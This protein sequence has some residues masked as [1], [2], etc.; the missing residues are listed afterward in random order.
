MS[1]VLVQNELDKLNI[2]LKAAIKAIDELKFP[3]QPKEFEAFLKKLPPLFRLSSICEELYD[4]EEKSTEQEAKSTVAD[5]L[6]HVSIHL[7]EQIKLFLKKV[8]KY[9]PDIFKAE[10]GNKI[11][12]EAPQRP[13][14]E[15]HLNAAFGFYSCSLLSI[16]VNITDRHEE[17]QKSCC[18]DGLIALIFQEIFPLLDKIDWD[19]GSV[20]EELMSRSMDIVYNCCKL[21]ANH[22]YYLEINAVDVLVQLRK[23]TNH[24]E[25]NDTNATALLTL[26]YLIDESNNDKIICGHATIETL[27]R[28][29]TKCLKKLDHVAYGFHAEELADGLQH[30]SVPDENKA[31]ICERG[32]HEVLAALLFN[33]MNDEEIISSC[34]AL[35][36]LCFSEKGRLLTKENQDLMKKLKELSKSETI[37]V[38][39]A[40]VGVLWQLKQAEEKEK[41]AVA[42]SGKKVNGAGHIML[43]YQWDDQKMVK[44]IAATLK[45]RGYIV[46]IDVEKIQGNIMDAMADAVEQASVIVVCI[47]RKYKNSP[48]CRA[49]ADYSFQLKKKV[50]PLMM[51]KDYRPDGWIGLLLGSKLRIDFTCFEA[52]AHNME[53]L[54][55]Q[56]DTICPALPEAQI[57]QNVEEPVQAVNEPYLGHHPLTSYDIPDS[58]AAR[59]PVAEIKN[60]SMNHER[61]GEISQWSN[62]EVLQWLREKSLIGAVKKDRLK[63]L[64]GVHLV[65]LYNLRRE[66]PK[67]YYHPLT[68]AQH[69][70]FNDL[71]DFL[72]FTNHIDKL[73]E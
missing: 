57:T 68:F 70:G 44:D 4:I 8:M 11:E 26:G 43:S 34:N 30:L 12:Y 31:L 7:P 2:G 17:T 51:E 59:T 73:F 29:L 53:L 67:R 48:N 5:I 40:A 60:H 54:C 52:F 25:G 63:K 22:K 69:L 64:N 21:S 24:L 72:A 6:N 32:G 3:C 23:D 39:E 49:E 1:L 27:I 65:M 36:S 38:K 13:I 14:K 55:R 19:K 62:I 47:S 20:R 37:H 35:W 50:I 61:I 58:G 18:R 10:T 16:L 41:T 15:E 42:D 45:E 46:W 9:Y 66:C 71:L 28:Y 56:L 33:A